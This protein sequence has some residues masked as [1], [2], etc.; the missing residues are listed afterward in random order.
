MNRIQKLIAETELNRKEIAEYDR[1]EERTRSDILELA[2]ADLPIQEARQKLLDA[3]ISLDLITAKRE[4]T[5]SPA[6]QARTE[7][8]DTLSRAVARWNNAVTQDKE[9]REAAA[10]QSTVPLFGSHAASSR[11][12]NQ[13]P[14]N[15]LP[16]FHNHRLAYFDDA[17]WDQRLRLD[18]CGLARTFLAHFHRFHDFLSPK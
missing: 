12:W 8:E 3:R 2:R 13:G 15:A 4:K 6:N 18:L 16:I 10:I 14:L 9:A 5:E 7:L 11:W 1:M 17:N